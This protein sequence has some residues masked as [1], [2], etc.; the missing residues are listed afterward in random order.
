[1][2][3]RCCL[4]RHVMQEAQEGSEEHR[5]LLEFREK[6]MA[7]GS[8]AAVAVFCPINHPTRHGQQRL[9]DPQYRAELLGEQSRSSSAKVPK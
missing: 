2:L 6:L 5:K 7:K 1:M 3:V 4:H 9:L 8:V